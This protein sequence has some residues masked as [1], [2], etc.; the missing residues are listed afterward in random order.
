MYSTVIKRNK[1]EHIKCDMCLQYPKGFTAQ[2][3]D[4]TPA[5][6][7]IKLIICENCK[8]REMGENK[9]TIKNKAMTKG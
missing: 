9:P 8:K 6:S 3:Y 7:K 1:K 2:Y 4:F 5:L